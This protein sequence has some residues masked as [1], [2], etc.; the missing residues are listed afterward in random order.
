MEGDG[1]NNEAHERGDEGEE[2]HEGHESEADVEAR[3]PWVRQG[4]RRFR[5]SSYPRL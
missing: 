5:G 3:R 4:G 2:D 1:S